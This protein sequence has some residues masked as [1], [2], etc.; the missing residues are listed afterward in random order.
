LSI[1]S[2]LKI[3]ALSVIAVCALSLPA[4]CQSFSVDTAVTQTAGQY[5]YAFTLNYDQTGATQSL[6]DNVWDWTFYVDPSLPT[7]TDITTP[8]G[9]KSS[10][11]ASSGQVDFY[12]EGPNGFG[13]G[14]F[15]SYVI[16]PGQS[17][18]GFGLT[19][20]AAPDSSI[21]YATDVQYNQDA[22]VALLPGSVPAAVPEASA[23]VSLGVLLALGGVGVMARRR[24]Q[25]T[26]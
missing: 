5:S 4:Y 23:S 11:D 6:T 9:W 24:M 26:V 25:R 19:T 10:F 8:T 7:L 15:G 18:S 21:A 16:L 17:L 22:A 3:S 1:R 14:D 2:S 13:S 12:T 20:P